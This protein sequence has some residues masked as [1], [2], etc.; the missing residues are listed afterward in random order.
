MLSI[1]IK[2]LVMYLFFVITLANCAFAPLTDP[3]SPQTIGKGNQSQQ[4][5]AGYPYLGYVYTMG[6]G[7]TFDL[8]LQ[9]ESQIKG[10]SMGARILLQATDY[11]ETEWSGS[12]LGGAGLTTEGSYVYGG[13]VWGRKFGFYELTLTPRLNYTNISR[14][15]DEDVTEDFQDLYS[16]RFTEK[17]DYFYASLSVANTFWFRPSFGFTLT[18]GGAY[19]FPW[20]D[21]VDSSFVAPYGGIGLIFK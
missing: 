16:L 17:G 7:E 9:M 8:G 20:I 1:R 12:L 18:I 13:M 15:I 21:S 6:V 4:I 5:A 19:L 10:F 14:D 3:I 2:N 11:S